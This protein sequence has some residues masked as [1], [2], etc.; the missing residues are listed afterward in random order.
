M[1]DLHIVVARYAGGDCAWAWG[2]TVDEALSGG[3]QQ[4]AA[5]ME[6]MTEGDILT[7]HGDRAERARRWL[8]GEDNGIGRISDLEAHLDEGPHVHMHVGDVYGEGRPLCGAPNVPCVGV[9]GGR[10]ST[11]VRPEFVSCPRCR[12]RMA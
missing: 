11:T 10:D 3:E 7:L 2:S 6:G 9:V 8:Q 4:C 1:S 12:E 5:D